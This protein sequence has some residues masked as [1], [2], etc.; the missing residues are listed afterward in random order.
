MAFGLQILSNKLEVFSLRLEG[1]NVHVL[2]GT[3]VVSKCRYMIHPIVLEF[4]GFLYRE[5]L[6]I[7]N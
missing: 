7:K 1:F 6:Q 5:M 3:K 4:R 2:F